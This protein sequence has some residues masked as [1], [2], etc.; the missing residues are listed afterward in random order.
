MSSISGLGGDSGQ[1]AYAASKAAIANL[2]KSINKEMSGFGIVANCVSPGLIETKM[3]EEITPEFREFVVRG[4]LL[5]R[6][7]K[8][9]EVASLITYLALDAPSYLINQNISISGGL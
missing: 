6:S 5:K 1:S 2:T 8:P 3:A 4:T 7:G 9:S